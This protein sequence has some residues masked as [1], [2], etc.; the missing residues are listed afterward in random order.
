MNTLVIAEEEEGDAVED[1]PASTP[2][3]KLALD[4]LDSHF[5]S[6]LKNGG[7]PGA[8]LIEAEEESAD[9]Q[10]FSRIFPSQV[11]NEIYG[12]CS[13]SKSKEIS[14]H[15]DNSAGWAAD[16]GVLQK[17]SGSAGCSQ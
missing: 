10:N 16:S 8:K 2:A 3:V 7:E 9:A 12:Y 6:I 15:H 4:Q 11:P 14:L 5:A 13:E 17:H 1:F